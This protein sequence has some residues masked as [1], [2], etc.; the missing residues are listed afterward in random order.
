[1][2][3]MAD[4]NTPHWVVIVRRERTDVYERLRRTFGGT[5]LVE[6]LLERRAGERRKGSA[7]DRS[8][9]RQTERR[10]PAA[11]RGAPLTSSHRLVQHTEAYQVLEAESWVLMECPR[12][13]A[14]LE[15]EMPR[16]GEL[17]ARLD[18]EVLHQTSESHGI[19]HFVETQAYRATGRSLLACRLLARVVR[20]AAGNGGA[21]TIRGFAAATS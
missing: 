2:P 19:K 20:A 15:L 6:V 8:E 1:M 7:R 18:L 11:L 10:R 9:R 3:T 13:Q 17:P 14:P 12:C 21:P 5:T 4:T 16:F